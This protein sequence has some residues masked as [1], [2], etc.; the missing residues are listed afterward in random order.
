VDLFSFIPGKS[1]F[2]LKLTLQGYD[3]PGLNRYHGSMET[4]KSNNCDRSNFTLSQS[5]HFQIEIAGR[6]GENWS[7]WINEVDI[8]ID[9]DPE[10]LVT[11]TLT[12]NFD[13][14]GLIGLLR[15]LYSLGYPLISVNCIKSLQNNDH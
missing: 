8:Q 7:D 15:Q 11:T 1:Q 5:I 4:K 12:G 2:T 9:T 13:Q 6:P 14:A 10:G 3:N